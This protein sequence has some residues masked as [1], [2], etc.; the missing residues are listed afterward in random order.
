MMQSNNDIPLVQFENHFKT[1]M[2]TGLM[3]KKAII[4]DHYN[5][6]PY[7]WR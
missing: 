3:T 2:K 4:S 5:V 7:L 6:C 1:I